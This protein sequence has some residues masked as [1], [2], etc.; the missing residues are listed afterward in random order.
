MSD[1]KRA[2]NA[3]G[4]ACGAPPAPPVAFAVVHAR[5]F[6]WGDNT[7]FWPRGPHDPVCLILVQQDRVAPPFS[8]GRERYNLHE[9]WCM[10]HALV[11]SKLTRAQAAKMAADYGLP[12]HELLFVALLAARD[13]LLHGWEAVPSFALTIAE[14]LEDRPAAL[15]D[16]QRWFDRKFPWAAGVADAGDESPRKR[17]RLTS[18][19]N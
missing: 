19:E 13:A 3:A 9:L 8:Y 5:S 11:V 7:D 14:L 18:A 2:A 15:A 17:A 1:R 6:R 10:R 16:F 4:T 12:S